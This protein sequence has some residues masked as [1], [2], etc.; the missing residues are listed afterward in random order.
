M[1]CHLCR[2]RTGRCHGRKRLSSHRTDYNGHLDDLLSHV[3]SRHER[4]LLHFHGIGCKR[5]PSG[6]DGGGTGCAAGAGVRTCHHGNHAGSQSLPSRLA[7]RCTGDSQ[8]C[9]CLFCHHLCTDVIPCG[10]HHHGCCHPCHRKHQ[11]TYA[12]QYTDEC[13]EHHPQLPVDLSYPYHDGFGSQLHRM[14]RR[15][16]R[17][18]CRY[19]FC[20]FSDFGRH[21]D[22]HCS[23]ALP[24]AGPFRS[25]RSL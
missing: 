21:I 4:D 6:K 16:G 2:Y 17:G 12:H 7:G 22:D 8:R 18:R 15:L 3:R 11:N 24:G 20:P 5:C 10:K 13:R 19:C 1:H 9:V 14:G 23:M 25:R